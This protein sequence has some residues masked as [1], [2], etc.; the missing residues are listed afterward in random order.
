MGTLLPSGGLGASRTKTALPSWMATTVVVGGSFL[1]QYLARQDDPLRNR[2]QNGG[3]KGEGLL[4][5]GD[6]TSS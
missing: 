4:R 6:G 5:D 3:K 2:N 1:A